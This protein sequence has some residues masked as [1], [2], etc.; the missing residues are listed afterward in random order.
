MAKKHLARPHQRE[1]IDDVLAGFQSHE[2]GQL[3]MA[4]GTGKT[5]TTRWIAEDLDAELTLVLVPS[6]SLLDQFAAE[7]SAHSS[8]Q[9]GSLCVCS[10]ET[11]GSDRHS[12]M[13]VKG[14]S[15]SMVY[16]P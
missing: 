1:A 13:S 14:N 8:A 7:W 16:C 5:L 10:D 6:I 3:I 4:C 9:F 15:A 2:R 12:Q 11:V